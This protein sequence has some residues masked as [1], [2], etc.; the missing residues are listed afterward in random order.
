MS[1]LRDLE[2]G[3]CLSFSVLGRYL[4]SC[5]RRGGLLVAGRCRQMRLLGRHQRLCDGAAEDLEEH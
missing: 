2:L 5:K 1:D 3:D 4:L